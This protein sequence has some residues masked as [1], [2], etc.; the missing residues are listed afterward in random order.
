MATPLASPGSTGIAWEN[1][2][3]PARD[4]RLRSPV[5]RISDCT[6]KVSVTTSDRDST[7]E[8]TGSSTGM[9]YQSLP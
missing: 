4:A 8:P 7:S 3:N 9:T 2:L 6:P 1:M 5:G